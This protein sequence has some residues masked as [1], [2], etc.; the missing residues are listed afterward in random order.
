MNLI[1][2]RISFLLVV[3]VVFLRLL[4]LYYVHVHGPSSETIFSVIFI[5]PS[6]SHFPTINVILSVHLSSSFSNVKIM[7]MNHWKKTKNLM[8]MKMMRII[9][10]LW[11]YG[12]YVI[13]LVMI[14]VFN[15]F[16]HIFDFQT[17]L[18]FFPTFPFLPF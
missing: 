18:P 6:F 5:E 15:V 10:V 9:V 16:N 4:C 12:F 1:W 3:L 2:M 7:K 11:H 17:F 8:M 14:E 13:I